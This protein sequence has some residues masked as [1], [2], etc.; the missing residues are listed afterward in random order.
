MLEILTYSMFSE[1]NFYRV[2]KRL[3]IWVYF[4]NRSCIIL[5]PLDFS[6]N[7]SNH[8]K[9]PTNKWQKLTFY[10]GGRSGNTLVELTCFRA[11]KGKF[12]SGKKIKILLPVAN[13]ISVGWHK[14]LYISTVQCF[15]TPALNIFNISSNIVFK[16]SH[17]PRMCKVTCLII[18]Y[19]FV[20]V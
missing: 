14:Y 18:I 19:N 6:V 10:E 1:E 2:R 3:V 4:N 9:I 17:L 7:N 12:L 8:W 15:I 5:I 11:P 16:L 20:T 13:I